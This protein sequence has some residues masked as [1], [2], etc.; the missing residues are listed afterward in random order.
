MPVDTSPDSDFAHAVYRW[1]AEVPEGQVTSY[2][3]LARL[4]GY[5]RHARFVGRLMARLPASSRLPWW[6]V[7]RSDGSLACGRRQE[8]RLQEEGVVLLKG[9][10]SFGRNGFLGS[11]SF[12]RH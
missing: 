11:E 7:V 4:A 9:R 10:I 8:E 1:L 5:P 3:Q 12:L 2:G 6:R